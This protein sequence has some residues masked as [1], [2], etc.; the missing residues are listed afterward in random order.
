MRRIIISI[1]ILATVALA[2]AVV[3]A[4]GA[5][6]ATLNLTAV[7]SPTVSI[8]PFD[9]GEA[10]AT[11][12]SGYLPTGGGPLNGAI[13]LAYSTL[14]SDGRGWTAAGLNTS[15]FTAYSMSVTVICAKGTRGLKVRAATASEKRRAIAALRE[16]SGR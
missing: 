9:I 6:T 5:K 14:S 15:E 7:D 13:D 10:T 3:S 11:C 8:P 1:A 2:G 12:P 4:D 16:R